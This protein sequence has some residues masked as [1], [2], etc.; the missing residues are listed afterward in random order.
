LTLTVCGAAEGPTALRLDSDCAIDLR[1]CFRVGD[2]VVR[3]GRRLR[4]CGADIDLARAVRWNPA[5]RPMSAGAQRVLANLRIARA[6][7]AARPRSQTSILSREARAACASLEN[8]CRACDLEAA[9]PEASRLI[10]WGEGLTPAGDDFL[11]GLMSGLDAFV[12]ASEVRPSFLRRLCAAIATR[13]D[14]TTP[15]AAHYLRLATRGH[16]TGDLHR[17][18]DA[19]LSANEPAPLEQA[20]DDALALGAT[21]GSD[22]VTGLLSGV[23]AWVHPSPAEGSS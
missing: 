8:A 9:L 18:R 6:K 15:I 4:S 7:L 5:T 1:A 3:R 12:A 10:G 23:C 2:A 11:V 14:L 19:V 22:L 16:F 20:L 21:S 17:V 13:A